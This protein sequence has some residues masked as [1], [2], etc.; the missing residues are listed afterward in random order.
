MTLARHIAERIVA[1]RAD[2]LPPAAL[3]WSKVAVMD[4]LGVALAGVAE[5]APVTLAQVIGVQ[6]T[7]GEAFMHKQ[8][9]F[10][11]FSGPGNF[12]AAQVLDTWGAPLDIVEP[13]ASYKLYPCCYSTHAPIEAA[14]NLVREHGAFDAADVERIDS[15]TAALR[16]AHTDRAQPR[17]GLEAKFSVQYCV[18]LAL[19]NG[20]VLLQDFEGEAWRA[21]ALQRVLVRVHA[22]PHLDG[23][24]EPG[25]DFAAEVKITLRDGR[26]GAASAGST[27]RRGVNARVYAL[28]GSAAGARAAQIR[29]R[30][31]LCNYLCLLTI[32]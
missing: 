24:F 2:N 1:M 5:D 27:G 28:A 8:G 20:R 3:Q 23:Q 26:A 13:G 11:L 12:D 15:W 7:G 18:A 4:T 19:L 17:T 9:F 14:L 32:V 30:W 10:N 16:L 21:P 22:A 6:T 29:M 25:Q 31:R